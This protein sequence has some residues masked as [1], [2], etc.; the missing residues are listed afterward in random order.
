[1]IWSHP[2]GSI[3]PSFTFIFWTFFFS[4]IICLLLSPRFASGPRSHGSQRVPPYVPCPALARGRG[5]RE[6]RERGG[7]VL[8]LVRRLVQQSTDGPAAL[9]GQEAPQ[10]RGQGTPPGAASGQS[11][12]H[13]EHRSAPR[14]PHMTTARVLGPGVRKRDKGRSLS[15]SGDGGVGVWTR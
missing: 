1:M 12:C 13:G 2:S 3:V 7:Q 6:Q 8:L 9:R 10:E 5:R 11:G 14:P 4:S 15:R